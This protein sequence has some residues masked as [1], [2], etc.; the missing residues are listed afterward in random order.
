M[1]DVTKTS[2]Q[3]QSEK[4]LK[5]ADA[6]SSRKSSKSQQ[7]ESQK[8]LQSQQS[9]SKVSQ[10]SYISNGEK[11]S[12]GSGKKSIIGEKTSSVD[13]GGSDVKSVRSSKLSQKALS[14]ES[15]R[16]LA[17]SLRISPSDS[18]LRIS[19]SDSLRPRSELVVRI[20]EHLGM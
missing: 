11:M 16:S 10:K 7:L 19:P 15:L 14:R 4:S 17:D 5:S 3:K 12:N 18:A 8:S 6:K 20:T 1:S 13:F 9:K 2:S